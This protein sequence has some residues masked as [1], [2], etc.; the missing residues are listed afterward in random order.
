MESGEGGRRGDGREPPRREEE[1]R[2]RVRE[3]GEDEREKGNQ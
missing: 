2:E 1:E 3:G